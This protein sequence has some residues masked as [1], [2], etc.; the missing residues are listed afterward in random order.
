MADTVMLFG[1]LGW[2]RYDG[3]AEQLC[4]YFPS[5]G[6]GQVTVEFG[7]LSIVASTRQTGR[8]L[9]RSQHHL[10][11]AADQARQRAH[12]VRDPLAIERGVRPG[13]CS[14]SRPRSTRSGV[15]GSTPGIDADT[16]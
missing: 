16:M 11:L 15:F 12:A 4:D 5:S 10:R 3:Q 9:P 2:D 1:A 7:H 8:I 14:T 6:S 13:R